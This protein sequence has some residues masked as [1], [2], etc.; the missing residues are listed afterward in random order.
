VVERPEHFTNHEHCDECA[1]A[2]AFFASHTVESLGLLEVPMETLPLSFLTPH[3]FR[4]FL[5]GL[6]LQLERD[7]H[8]AGDILFQLENRLHVLGADE[9]KMARDALYGVYERH[10]DVIHGGFFAYEALWR[11]LDTLDVVASDPPQSESP[12]ANE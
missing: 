11:V 8:A 10:R 5:P 4:Y 1:D 7:P 2:D 6:L 9:A 12:S 3:G